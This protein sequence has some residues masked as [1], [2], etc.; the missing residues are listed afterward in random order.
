MKTLKVDTKSIEQKK[1][2]FKSD[3]VEDMLIELTE[4]VQ[5]LPGTAVALVVA[6]VGVD[7]AVDLIIVTDSNAINGDNL[8]AIQTNGSTLYYYV[9]GDG[10]VTSWVGY[11]NLPEGLENFAPARAYA[12]THVVWADRDENDP[13]NYEIADVVV[14][15]DIYSAPVYDPQLITTGINTKRENALG[16]D[17]DGEYN[18]H[19]VAFGLFDRDELLA[20]AENTVNGEG[21][22][23][24]Q[25]NF[26]ASNVNEG[27]AP[28]T[29]N[30]AKYGIYAGQVTRG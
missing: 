1:N 18:E 2:V 7:E 23:T 21:L 4:G 5:A 19:G 12:V 6:F 10:K 28:I 17:S 8:Q 3:D 14:F 11:R 30:F 22:W 25:L 27:E 15:E 24:P 29:E 13:L 16:K 26:Y 20:R 9:D